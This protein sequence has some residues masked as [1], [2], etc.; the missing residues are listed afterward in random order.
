LSERPLLVL[1]EPMSGL[2]PKARALF[3]ARLQQ[4][5]T[6]GTTVLFSTHLLDDL[7]S[8][9]DQIAVLHDG[10][11]RFHG[12]LAS[13]M[14]TYASNTLEMAFLSCIDADPAT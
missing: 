1:D 13:F 2:D 5:R 7:A 10:R 6:A 3:K 4:L 8:I 14:Q 9:C 12:S 11:I